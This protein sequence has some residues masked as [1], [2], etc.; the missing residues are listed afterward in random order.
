[1]TSVFLLLP[2]QAAFSDRLHGSAYGDKA[3]ATLGFTPRGL[4]DR[5]G[6]AHALHDAR[7]QSPAA[8]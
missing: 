3:D 5:A 2:P 7:A 8:G 1:M 4:S 6:L